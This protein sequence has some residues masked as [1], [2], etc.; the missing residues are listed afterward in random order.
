MP[1]FGTGTERIPCEK[2]GAVHVVS[3]V[4]YPGDHENSLIRC[5][6]EGCGGIVIET[7]STRSYLEAKLKDAPASKKGRK[8]NKRA[9]SADAKPKRRKDR[10]QLAK[11]V[12]DI[13]TDD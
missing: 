5:L 6:V 8:P 12:V 9:K 2:C 10:N 11:Q 3:Y 13:A 4:D 7:R 1:G